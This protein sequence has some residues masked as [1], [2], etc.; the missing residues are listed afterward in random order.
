MRP[1]AV[2]SDHS[3]AS[4]RNSRYAHRS[5]S[6]LGPTDRGDERRWNRLGL[7]CC[8]RPSEFVL[9]GHTKEVHSIVFSP[10]GQRIASASGDSTIKLWDAVTGEDV[11]TLRGHRGVLDVAYSPDGQQIASAGTD[12]VG[13]GTGP[14]P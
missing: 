13:S 9:R 7:G 14:R 8:D 6:T 5:R 1:P 3:G 11:F 10:D 2:S 4:T 12:G